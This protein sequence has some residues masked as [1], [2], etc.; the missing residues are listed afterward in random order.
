MLALWNAVPAMD[1]IFDDVMGSAFAGVR[2]AAT[3]TPAIDVRTKENELLVCLDVPGVK[4]EDID[5]TVEN[6]V[7]TIKGSRK[8]E[9]GKGEE[10]RI[11]RTYGSFSVSYTLGELVDGEHLSAELADGVLTIR[12]P[13]HPKAQPRR[14][15]IQRSQDVK[16]ELA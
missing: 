2:S 15:E 5:V 6:R 8:L 7:L 10:V 13:K 14:I 3:Y 4:R 11:G 12:L 1:R 16:K 9:T